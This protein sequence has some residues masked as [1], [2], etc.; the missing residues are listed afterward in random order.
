MIISL[1]KALSISIVLFL[2]Q[3]NVSF[4]MN[5]DD[6]D[7]PNLPRANP[8][9]FEETAESR[10]RLN[11]RIQQRRAR[12]QQELNDRQFTPEE[13]IV[14]DQI[15]EMVRRRDANARR[16]IARIQQDRRNR[17]QRNRIYRR[18]P[19]FNLGKNNKPGPAA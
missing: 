7:R 13:L 14:R 11:R 4:S 3:T 10:E 12:E 19:L 9:V 6:G 5:S 16:N 2:F 17:L 15:A 18:N 8:S 1:K